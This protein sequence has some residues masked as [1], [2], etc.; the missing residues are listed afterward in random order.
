V[1]ILFDHNTPAPLRRA[2]SGHEVLTAWECGW[3]E[4]TNGQLLAAAESAGFALMIT[5]DKSIRYQ[6]NLSGR[7]IALLVLS[8]NDWA[9]I[10]QA[11]DEILASVDT[12]GAGA[13]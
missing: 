3:A 9:A 8:T 7:S 10:R 13:S 2:L 1:R 4:L 12:M 11:S 5:T 6:Q